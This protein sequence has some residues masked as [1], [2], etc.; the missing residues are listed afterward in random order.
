[1]QQADL[2]LPPLPSAPQLPQGLRR[3]RLTMLALVLGA[4]PVIGVA[5]A[6]SPLLGFVAVAAVAAALAL[7]QRPELAVLVMVTV[8]PAAAGLQRGLLVPGLRVSEA[9]I[10]GLGALVL[11]FASR[12]RRPSWTPVEWA[13]LAYAILT[14]AFGGLDLALRHASLEFEDLGTML[15]P[16][17]FVVLLRA[18]IVAMD[19]ERDRWR[20]INLMLGAAALIALVALAQ[21]ADLG[22]T[23]SVLATLTGGSLYDK[24]LGLGVGRI[25]GPFNI[26]HELAGFLMPSIL[27]S[28]SLMIGAEDS[29]RRWRYGF[30]FAVSVMALISTAAAGMLIATTIGA[31]Y[32]CW[33]RQVL[34][35]ALAF[36]G[37]VVVIGA[38]AFGSILGNRAEQQYVTPSATAYA[39]PYAPQSVSY[40]YSLFRVQNAPALQRHWGTGYGPD[41]PPQLALGNFPYSETA[42]VSLL[43]RGG[44]PLLM[45]FL[46]LLGCLAATAR[47]CQRAAEDE[48][49]WS[50]ATVVLIA[51]VSYLFLQLIESYLLDA[52]PPHAFWAYA[53][54]MLAGAGPRLSRSGS[55]GSGS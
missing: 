4:A 13:L 38:I 53:G 34:Y 26:W 17:Q 7:S 30:V 25:T 39:I 27:M 31:L 42:Y 49:Q 48:L 3:P 37:P 33:R 14:V 52:G 45:V 47:R 44:V 18:V 36:A 40:R 35:A 22:P 5:T 6:L 12:E 19:E 50:L 11:V 15:G 28:L 1:M 24:S 16:M 46:A 32:I 9:L 2:S 20:A 51:T 29:R 41:L 43:L 10:V 8:A 54:L 23:R 55:R 21:A